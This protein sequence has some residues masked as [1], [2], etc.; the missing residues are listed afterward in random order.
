MARDR[1][2]EPAARGHQPP[3]GKT[4]AFIANAR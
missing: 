2:R 1:R 3:I 4:G